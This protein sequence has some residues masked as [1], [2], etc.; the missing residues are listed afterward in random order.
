MQLFSDGP[1]RSPGLVKTQ[2]EGRGH[3]CPGGSQPQLITLTYR[4]NQ[5]AA[6]TGG[7]PATKF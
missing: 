1:Y 7:E 3:M 2:R 4:I 5:K 6:K